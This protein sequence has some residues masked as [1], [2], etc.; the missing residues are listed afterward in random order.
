[1]SLE[2]LTDLVRGF[3]ALYH[4]LDSV[5]PVVTGYSP[6][7]MDFGGAWSFVLASKSGENPAEL[8][9]EQVDAAYR[10]SHQCKPPLLR[11]DHASPH[12]LAA[13]AAEG[14]AGLGDM[15]CHGRAP[16]SRSLNGA[17][18]SA[19]CGIMAVRITAV[20]GRVHNRFTIN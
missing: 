12:L 6:V 11:R 20:S 9:P 4:T 19:L 18:R 2:A 7:I 3:T 1:M 17:R 15:D 14:R 16:T 5:F 13:Q 8:E 10:R